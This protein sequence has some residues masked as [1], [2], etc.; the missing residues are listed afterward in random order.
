VGSRA[1]DLWRG[2]HDREK[3][4]PECVEC[5]ITVAENRFY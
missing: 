4:Q 1:A 3:A 2:R 5:N